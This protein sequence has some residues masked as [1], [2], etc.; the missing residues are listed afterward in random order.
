[1]MYTA[2]KPGTDYFALAH[3]SDEYTFDGHT[4][5]LT[6]WHR[7]LYAMTDAFTDAGFRL[8]VISEPP[9]LSRP[10]RAPASTA[11]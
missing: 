3:W 11:A 5:A 4:A 7:P 6:F 1:M 2:V 10:A 8:S 9:C